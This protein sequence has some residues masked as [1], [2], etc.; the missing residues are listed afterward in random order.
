MDRK[1]SVRVVNWKLFN[2]SNARELF[3]SLLLTATLERFENHAILHSSN[4]SF[5]R[6]PAQSPYYIIGLYYASE[7]THVLNTGLVRE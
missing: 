4:L 7:S 3:C 6:L 1:N 2:D 5:H